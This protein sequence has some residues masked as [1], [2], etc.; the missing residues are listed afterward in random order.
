MEYLVKLTSK[1]R[2]AAVA[3]GAVSWLTGALVAGTA[4]SASAAAAHTFTVCAQGNYTAY[5][6]LPQQGGIATTLIRPGQCADLYISSGSTYGNVWGIYNNNPN[7]KFHVGTAHFTASKGWKGAAKGT[8][9]N[10]YLV[11]LH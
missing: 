6:D 3:V 7:A 9:N 4:G 8:T 2:Q 10:P 11:N 1:V 5:A